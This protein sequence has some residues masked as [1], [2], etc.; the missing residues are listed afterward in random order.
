MTENAESIEIA[1]TVPE[2]PVTNENEPEVP[3]VVV[4]ESGES[5][6]PA[7]VVETAIDH[8]GRLVRIETAVEL[9]LEKLSTV[10]VKAETALVVADAV[11]EEQQQL[12]AEIAEVAEEQQAPAEADETPNREHG[13]YRQRKLFGKGD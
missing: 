8:E 7:V 1:V 5:E 6:T 9:I 2:I 10:E 13:F 3:A 12:H 11:V 4:V